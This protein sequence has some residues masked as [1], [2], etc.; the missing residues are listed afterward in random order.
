MNRPRFLLVF[1]LSFMHLAN[2]EEIKVVTEHFPPYQISEKGK[3]VTGV[4]VEFIKAL[5]NEVNVDTAINVY[6][7]AR[8]YNMALTYPNVLIFSMAR[9]PERENLFHWIGTLD[10]MCNH[11]WALKKNS[12]IKIASIAEAKQYLVG[13]PRDDTVHHY[14]NKNGFIDKKNMYVV[15]TREQAVKMLFR[16]RVDILMGAELLIE[17]RV[18]R[19]GYDFNK[20]QKVFSLPSINASGLSVAF[21]KSTPLALVHKFQKAF[22]KLK[23]DSKYKSISNDLNCK[24]N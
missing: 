12:T 2:S 10:S 3:P 22:E 15:N 4:T 1:L 19:L 24:A 5:L 13:V 9:V 17:Q 23:A 6:P 7:W 14:L 21:S 16:G 8:A 11:L 18:N 20:L